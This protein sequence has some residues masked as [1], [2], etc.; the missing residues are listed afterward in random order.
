MRRMHK[1][2]RPLLAFTVMETLQNNSRYFIRSRK[3]NRNHKKNAMKKSVDKTETCK[4]NRTPKSTVENHFSVT[5]KRR[6]KKKKNDNI[7]KL[8]EADMKTTE[9]KMLGELR[10]SSLLTVRTAAQSLVCPFTIIFHSKL[11]LS[12]RVDLFDRHHGLRLA[13]FLTQNASLGR[14]PGPRMHQF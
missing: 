7:W 14:P 5:P 12:I 6:S 13:K 3:I 4:C 11:L 2:Q 10:I 8:K 9:W 1:R